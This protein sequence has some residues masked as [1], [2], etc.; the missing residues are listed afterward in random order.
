MAGQ[1]QGIGRVF[2]GQ[3]LGRFWGVVFG[4]SRIFASVAS[5]LLAMVAG[6]AVLPRRLWSVASV[7]SLWWPSGAW[8]F[9]GVRAL[10]GAAA[11]SWGGMSLRCCWALG[12]LEVVLVCWCLERS[13]LGCSGCASGCF[14]RG[15]VGACGGAP[16]R[17]LAG[18]P[19]V[20][21]AVCPCSGGG[22]VLV[23][24]AGFSGSAVVCLSASGCG[25]SWHFSYSFSC[26]AVARYWCGVWG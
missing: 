4:M 23:L 3:L 25:M 21:G 18:V 17:S 5:T 8:A 10:V 26:A 16:A 11:V 15:S 13:C 24:R 2:S 19:R 14:M 22:L 12:F 7:R 1:F 9:P 20:P 6:A